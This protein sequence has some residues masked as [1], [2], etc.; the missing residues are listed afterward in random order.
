MRGRFLLPTFLKRH[1]ELARNSA[2]VYSGSQPEV[3]C[4]LPVVP[5]EDPRRRQMLGEGRAREN[6][7]P[8]PWWISTDPKMEAGRA[9]IV[10]T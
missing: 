1:E 6:P 3:T 7:L 9:R 8:L 10:E 5:R 2:S 4:I